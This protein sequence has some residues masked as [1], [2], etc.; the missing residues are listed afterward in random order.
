MGI[1]NNQLKILALIFM[2]VDHIGWMLFP[3]IAVFRMVGRLAYPIFA[4]MVAE[5]CSH[6]RSMG[7]H[8]TGLAI[9]ALLCQGVYWFVMGSLYQCIFV[10]F[11]L[12]VGLIWLIKSAL[13]R[14][15]AYRWA[16]AAA[17]LFGVFF[18]TWWLPRLLVGTDF[19]VDYGF[20]GVMLPV[21]IYFGRSKKEKLLI[22]AAGLAIMAYNSTAVQWLA[23][24]AVPLLALYNGKRGKL[25]LKWLFYVYYPAHL[26]VLQGLA[27]LSNG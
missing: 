15:T 1:N 8:L 24:F 18:I 4:Y 2:T 19:D 20:W 7:K 5:G 21:L 13:Q 6:T 26:V 22:T 23:L 3:Q 14:K 27:Y 16:F 11:S 12:S 17:G 25:P 9:S 10:T